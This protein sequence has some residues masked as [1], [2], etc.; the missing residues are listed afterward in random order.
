MVG[1]NRKEIDRSV[2]MG[3]AQKR[4]DAE[5]SG[6][7]ARSI[8]RVADEVPVAIALGKRR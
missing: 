3:I 1:K 8:V 2:S 4:A 7:C 6:R 5:I